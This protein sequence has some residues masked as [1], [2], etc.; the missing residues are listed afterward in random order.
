MINKNF[1]KERKVKSLWKGAPVL[2]N[3]VYDHGK[4]LIKNTIMRITEMSDNL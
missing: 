3:R 2:M 1:R 4:C